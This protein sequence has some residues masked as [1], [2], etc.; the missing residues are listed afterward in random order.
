MSFVGLR[1][2][3]RRKEFEEKSRDVLEKIQNKNQ[4]E[5]MRRILLGIQTK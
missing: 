5:K 1:K 2:P 3:E 4:D